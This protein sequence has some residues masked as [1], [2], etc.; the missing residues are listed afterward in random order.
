MEAHL[1]QYER[2]KRYLERIRKIYEGSY[3][4][5]SSE[6][7]E[8]EIVSF[9]IHCFHIMDWVIHLSKSPVSEQEINSFINSHNELKICADF[10]NGEK[11][12]RLTRTKRTGGQPHLAYRAY[13]V[14]HYT[15]ESGIA[16]KYKAS[17][18]IISGNQTYDALELAEKC[19]FLWEQYI[20]QLQNEYTLYE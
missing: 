7:Y 20:S 8:D 9:F 14:C 18:K 11:H 2:A 1:K 17:Y 19:I 5:G 10:C 4:P 13:G 3:Y 6:E 15:P 12:C 16:S